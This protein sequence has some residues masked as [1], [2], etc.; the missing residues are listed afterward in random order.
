MIAQR[1]R[2]RRNDFSLSIF[3]S[4][5]SVPEV[6]PLLLSSSSLLSSLE[7]ELSLILSYLSVT[8]LLDIFIMPGIIGNGNVK[9]RGVGNFVPT[10]RISHFK[11]TVSPS[12]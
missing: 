6:P 9:E 3:L 7:A 10:I 8:P 11:N 2:K 5:A 1:K 12:C 4:S